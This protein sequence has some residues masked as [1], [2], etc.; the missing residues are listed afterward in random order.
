MKNGGARPGAGRKSKAEELK[1]IERL[2]PMQDDAL[3]A[4]KKGIRKG[5]HAFLKLFMEYMYGK[6]HEKL[7][8]TSNGETL[9]KH[10][11]EFKDYTKPKK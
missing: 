11:V 8:V 10:V 2:S 3:E 1:L 9:G 7:D 6:P 4:L 5:E